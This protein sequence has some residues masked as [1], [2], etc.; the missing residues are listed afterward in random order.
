V[1]KGVIHYI[2]HNFW[3]LRSFQDLSDLQTQANQW[4]DQVA[5]VRTHGTTGQ[6]PVERFQPQTLRP[7]PE[8]LPDCRDTA[9]AKVHSDFSVR[10][11]GNSYTVPPWA[12]GK[13]V[14][15]KADHQ[16]LTIYLKEKAI[17]THPRSYKQRERIELPAHRD[18]AL[19]QKRRLW[20]SDLVQAFIS[21][22]EEAKA[23]LEHLSASQEPL[24]KTLEK[25]LALKDEY[26]PSALLEAIQR[27][28]L[29]KAYGAHYI[30]NILYQEMTPKTHH[31]PVRLKQEKLNRIRLEE[32]SLADYDALV[33]KRRNRS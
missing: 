6:K 20:R 15:V 31:P 21:L 16:T 30:K 24:K 32:P 13:Q 2:R 7:L 14:I 22:G 3:P 8:I 26:G 10:F 1:E 33:L 9:P 27:A 12:V 5:N 18:A 11:D 4:R 17:A 19:R 29:H 25:L 28:S 23:Y